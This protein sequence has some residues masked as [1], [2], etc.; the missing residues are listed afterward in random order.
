MHV[1]IFKCAFYVGCYIILSRVPCAYSSS[2]L[3]IHSK[4]GRVYTFTPNSL[5]S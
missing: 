2:L 5:T 4:H 1:F 3:V